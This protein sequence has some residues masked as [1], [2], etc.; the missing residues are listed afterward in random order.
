MLTMTDV[1]TEG[2]E[3]QS[4]VFTMRAGIGVLL[5]IKSKW[6]KNVMFLCNH[7]QH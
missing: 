4:T 2:K 3:T 7:I 6:K 5:R 1:Q